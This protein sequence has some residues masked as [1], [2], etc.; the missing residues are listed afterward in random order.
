VARLLIRPGET[1]DLPG[2]G[3]ITMEDVV[4]WGGLAVR[5]D[6]GR[7]P[8]LVSAIVLLGALVA[9]LTVRRR[10]LYVRVGPLREATGEHTEVTVAG[11]AKGQDSSLEDVVERLLQDIRAAVGGPT[12]D[13]RKKDGR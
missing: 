13:D 6:P 4:R 2:G 5:H 9:M 3:T 8:V 1:L 12:T 10:R 11:L 7:V